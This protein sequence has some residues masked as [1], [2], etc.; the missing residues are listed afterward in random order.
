MY[1]E[2]KS[3]LFR[4]GMGGVDGRDA[5]GVRPSDRW[6]GET[7]AMRTVE[8]SRKT[9]T[10]APADPKADQGSNDRHDHQRGGR[11]SG[12]SGSSYGGQGG[13]VPRRQRARLSLGQ[14]L[15]DPSTSRRPGGGVD[16][17]RRRKIL[18]GEP[19][20][21]RNHRRP[22]HSRT[23]NDRRPSRRSATTPAAEPG[24]QTA[25][26]SR[27]YQFASAGSTLS[28]SITGSRS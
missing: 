19:P 25:T 18:H 22:A 1:R 26:R 6:A 27:S 5:V 4:K 13:T 7:A 14:V 8:L 24:R 11:G 20:V 15:R 21:T 23:S 2:H 9:P 28:T 10:G 17:T 12:N 16:S 3:S